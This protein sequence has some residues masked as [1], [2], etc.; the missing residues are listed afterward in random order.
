MKRNVGWIVLGIGLIA[1]V[2]LLSVVFFSGRGW[3]GGYGGMMGGGYHMMPWYGSGG[4]GIWG[5]FWMILGWLIPLGIVILLIA[6]GVWLGN[7]LSQTKKGEL[8]DKPQLQACPQCAK[9]TEAE[10]NVC[11]YCGNALQEV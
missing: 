9:P 5:W 2:V 7:T 8:R 11:P 6:G 4:M 10:W 3:M 1:L